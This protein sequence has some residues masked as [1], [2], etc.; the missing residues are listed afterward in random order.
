MAEKH[1][2]SVLRGQHFETIDSFRGISFLGAITDVWQ[3]C[4]T[5]ACDG[6]QDRARLLAMVDEMDMRVRERRGR[7]DYDVA[8]HRFKGCIARD[9]AAQLNRTRQVSQ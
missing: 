9:M 8:F 7:G 6:P 1:W 4:S 3:F 5:A 2:I